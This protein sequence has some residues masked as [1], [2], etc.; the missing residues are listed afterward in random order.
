MSESNEDLIKTIE[1]LQKELYIEK[2]AHKQD[3]DILNKRID[4]LCHNPKE[5]N[6]ILI[7]VGNL[8][9]NI[10]SLAAE[11]KTLKQMLK[12][13]D[14]EYHDNECRKCTTFVT[15][16]S[17]RSDLYH[18]KNLNEYYKNELKKLE[19]KLE[20]Q[21][22][23]SE[24]THTNLYNKII[25]LENETVYQDKLI[26]KL[27]N[28]DDF[29]DILSLE[30]KVQKLNTEIAKRDEKIG[31]LEYELKQY[32]IIKST[33]SESTA[34]KDLENYVKYWQNEAIKNSFNK[35]Q[36]RESPTEL[37][38]LKA[39]YTKLKKA[40]D[41][42]VQDPENKLIQKDKEIK[43]WRSRYHSLKIIH[44]K[45]KK[46]YKARNGYDGRVLSAVKGRYEKLIQKFNIEDKNKRI[47]ELQS[48]YYTIKK[49]YETL[50]TKTENNKLTNKEKFNEPR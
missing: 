50:K 24:R 26:R 38:K 34:I 10:I 47:A 29:Q 43:L 33:Y 22:E 4:E 14:K 27:R 30:D 35:V 45:Y 42:L 6:E 13:H 28:V 37:T 12:Y 46:K 2:E 41:E 19:R 1:N 20:K 25:S 21:V 40:Y 23:S 31:S 15:T 39:K 9:N 32:K 5:G 11:N 48:K 7:Y 17:L 49:A 16:Q 8:K 18:E 3:L 44:D 36:K